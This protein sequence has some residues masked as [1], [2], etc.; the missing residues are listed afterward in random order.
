MLSYAVVDQ[1][2]GGSDYS[3]VGIASYTVKN[4]VYIYSILGCTMIT[5]LVYPYSNGGV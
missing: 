4:G 5:L 1:E 3:V 2:C